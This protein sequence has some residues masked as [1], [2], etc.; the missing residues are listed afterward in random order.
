MKPLSNIKLFPQRARNINAK[1]PAKPLKGRGFARHEAPGPRLFRLLRHWA[2][3][4][5]VEVMER[6][7]VNGFGRV[8]YV[9]RPYI[10]PELHRAVAANEPALSLFENAIATVESF[11]CQVTPAA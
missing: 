11:R 4:H 8:G 6:A 7:I 5:C 9:A 2:P 3:G 1:S 10:S